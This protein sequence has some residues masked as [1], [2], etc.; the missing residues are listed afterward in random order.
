VKRARRVGF[1]PWRGRRAAAQC[2]VTGVWRKKVLGRLVRGR[3]MRAAWAGWAGQRPRHNAGLAVVAQ[4]EGRGSGPAGVE[5]EAGRGWGEY[6]AG[7]EFK[8]NSFRISIYF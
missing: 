4:K 6:G 8:R 7:P 1:S 5:G 3:K 2:G